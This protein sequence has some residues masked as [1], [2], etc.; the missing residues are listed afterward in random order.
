MAVPFDGP[1]MKPS[2]YSSPFGRLP[3]PA[4]GPFARLE[5]WVN[6]MAESKVLSGALQLIGNLMFVVSSVWRWGGL[7]SG[8]TVFPSVPGW[9]LRH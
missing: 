4:V 8:A 2:R 9:L 5:N 3:A 7:Y 1:G 6:S